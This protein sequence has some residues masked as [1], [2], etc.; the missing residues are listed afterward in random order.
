MPMPLSI[1]AYLKRGPSTSKEIQAAT[2]LSQSSVARRL[3]ELGDNIVQIQEGRSIRYAATCN[4]LG[5]N[6]KIPLGLVDHLGKISVVAYLR[7]LTHG[8]YFL[9]PVTNISPLLLGERGNGLYDGLP[10]FLYDLRPQGF[11]GRQISRKMATRLEAFPSDPRQ[12]TNTHIG[13]YLISNGDDL[14]GNFILGEQSILR[15][16]RRPYGITGRL[17]PK[18]AEDVLKGEVPGSSAGGEQPKFTAFSSR[19]ESHII[20]KFSPRDDTDIAKRWRDILITEYHAAQIINANICPAARTGFLE[21]EGR[22]FLETHR[23]DRLGVFGRYSMISLQ[24]IDNEFTGIG[25]NWV[26]VMEALKA[27]GLVSR[28][29]AHVAG[30]LLYF[31]QLIHNTD[32]HLGNL[33][34]CI[35]GEMFR[36]LPCY[37]MCSMGFAPQSAGE[38]GPFF[39]DASKIP[40]PELNKDDITRLR[41]LAYAFWE[42][43]SGDEHISDEF[44]TFLSRRNPVASLPAD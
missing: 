15:L 27:Q 40:D 13:K 39:F 32:M 26:R 4:A 1:N 5:V 29:D 16:A 22:L 41:Q 2:G 34:L 7:P 44:R 18:M 10:Y 38:V 43:V 19:Y 35:D 11:L 23:F 33:S 42:N 6:D 21:A 3:R 8:G 14:P 36:L 28:Q 25:H 20:V 37:D 30:Q 12:W 24:A 9:Q 17:Y 31:G